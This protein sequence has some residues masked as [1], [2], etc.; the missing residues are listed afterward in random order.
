MMV[1]LADSSIDA[2]TQV[3]KVNERITNLGNIYYANDISRKLCKGAIELEEAHKQLEELLAAKRYPNWL[4]YICAIISATSF[5]VL[6]GA[7]LQECL[8]A[9]FNGVFIVISRMFNH[10]VEINR[11]VSNMV[12]CFVIATTTSLIVRIPGVQADI[13]PV[14]AGSIMPLLPGVALTNAIRDT[15]QGDYVSG[16][17]R[18]VEAFVTAAALAV[19]IFAG[20]ALGKTILGG[21]L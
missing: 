6:F 9:A 10:K 8:I 11:F 2:I 5:T 15:L 17:A 1:T 7:T 13:E 20:L 16:T 19:G 21:V 4:Q 14:I 18:L 12:V 3:R